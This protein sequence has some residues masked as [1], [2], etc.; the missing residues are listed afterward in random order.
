[1]VSRLEVLV[2][3]RAARP[4]PETP[5]CASVYA[6]L[7]V[8]HAWPALGPVPVRGARREDDMGNEVTNGTSRYVYALR[9]VRERDLQSDTASLAGGTGSGG[10][11]EPASTERDRDTGVHLL[12]E[13]LPQLPGAAAQVVGDV[14]TLKRIIFLIS[15][16][17]Q[18]TL[19]GAA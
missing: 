16:H 12:P 15:G 11:G 6:A 5:L 1:M 4:K 17:E 2:P 3:S 18:N 8:F 19:L 9:L 14:K 10:E 13:L 7:R